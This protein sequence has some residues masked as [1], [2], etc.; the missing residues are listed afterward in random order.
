MALFEK[1]W[2]IELDR[3]MIRFSSN[4]KE[5]QTYY[6]QNLIPYSSLNRKSKKIIDKKNQELLNNPELLNNEIKM[7]NERIRFNYLKS[8]GYNCNSFEYMG[9]VNGTMSNEMEYYLNS[10]VSENDILLGIHRIGVNDSKEKIED[11]LTNGLT[12][13][14][15]IRNGGAKS[16]VRLEHNVSFYTDNMV[17]LKELMHADIWDHSKGSILIRIPDND[18][19]DNIYITDNNGTPRLNPKYIVG[20]VPLSENRHIDKI[21]TLNNINKYYDDLEKTQELTEEYEQIRQEL[22]ND[23]IIINQEQEP[24]ITEEQTSSLRM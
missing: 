9:K 4:K 11:I 5:Y 8:L 17:I 6:A 21:I 10:M 22:E 3:L 18:L 13:T 23:N 12:M 20:Y 19:R 16:E 1:K 2:D 14:G 15:L 24:I 7:A